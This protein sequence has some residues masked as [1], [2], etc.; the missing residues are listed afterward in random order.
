ME[1]FEIKIKE[2]FHLIAEYGIRNK[3][4]DLKNPEKITEKNKI[5]FLSQVHKGFRLGQNLIIQ[6]IVPLLKELKTLKQGEKQA[7]RDKKQKFS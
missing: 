6:E 7:R 1:T 3:P 2:I 5:E 4:L